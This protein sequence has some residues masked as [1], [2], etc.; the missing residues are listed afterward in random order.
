MELKIRK[1]NNLFKKAIKVEFIAR[2]IYFPKFSE[3]FLHG[4]EQGKVL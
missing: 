4:L 3:R 1:L 2:Q